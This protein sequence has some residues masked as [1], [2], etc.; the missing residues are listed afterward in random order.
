MN[1]LVTGGAGFTPPLPTQGSQLSSRLEKQR[2]V[3]H[4]VYVLRS[5]RNSGWYIGCTSDL[6]NR[7]R[8][9]EDQNVTATKGKG[10]WELLYCECYREQAQADR[11]ERR[12]K[13]FGGAYRQ[14]RQRLAGEEM[15]T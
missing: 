14:L 11:R 10:P 15:A 4:H 5:L 8:L 2:S 7:L 12:L 3:M 9:H 6:Q 13:Q 1:V